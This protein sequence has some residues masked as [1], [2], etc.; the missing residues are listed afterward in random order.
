MAAA[1]NPAAKGL[2]HISARIAASKCAAD[3]VTAPW[4]RDCSAGLRLGETIS[5]VQRGSN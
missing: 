5:A 2:T 3:A 4:H 1:G